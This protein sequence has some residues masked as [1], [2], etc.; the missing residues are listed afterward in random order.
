MLSTRESIK[1]LFENL[2]ERR[3]RRACPR[4]NSPLVTYIDLREGNG[5]IAL[6]ISESGLAITAAGMLFAD[7][8]RAIRFQLPKVPG[9]IETSGRV[10]WVGDS[11]KAAGISFENIT[12]VDRERIRHWISSQVS[13]DDEIA[14]GIS[15]LA[16]NNKRSL[17]DPEPG[18]HQDQRTPRKLKALSEADEARF[19]A[20]FPSEST[21]H[22]QTAVV[23]DW[24]ETEVER[25]V[26][27]RVSQGPGEFLEDISTPHSVREELRAE[28]TVESSIENT[29]ALPQSVGG[30]AELVS[31]DA[32]V[33]SDAAS[34]AVEPVDTIVF[35]RRR[36]IIDRPENACEVN[37]QAI[38]EEAVAQFETPDF[39]L[40]QNLRLSDGDRSTELSLSEHEESQFIQEGPKESISAEG[41]NPGEWALPTF[42]YPQE[43]DWRQ[44]FDWSREPAAT[45]PASQ[46]AAKRVPER[47]SLPLILG[48]GILFAATCFIAGLLLGNGS[49]RRLLRFNGNGE[50][51][52]ST[53]AIS[54]RNDSGNSNEMA[55][56][57]GKLESSNSPS[58]VSTNTSPSD[59]PGN[60]HGPTS[61]QPPKG[62]Q[63][64]RSETPKTGNDLKAPANDSI[65]EAEDEGAPSNASTASDS[66]K[67]SS[68]ISKDP[69][70]G[71]SPFKL[72]VPETRTQPRSPASGSQQADYESTVD[73]PY[74]EV[75]S[76]ILVT[77]PDEKS[78][79]FRL[80]F[81]EVAVSA[82]GA[83][84]ISAQRF[85]LVPTLP[86]P[87][88]G[89]RPARLQAGVLIYHVDP[90]PPAGSD[91]TGG[92]VKV[93]AMIGKGGDVVEVR[94]V[95][96]P[97]SLIPRVVRAVREWRYTVTLLD[98][99]PLGAE[100][101]VVVEFR[102]RR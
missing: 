102:P 99:Q 40:D 9:W 77:P 42:T 13:A 66:R 59:S 23:R 3:D 17:E 46:Q 58:N 8:F 82:S 101:D 65:Q 21:L 95:S 32:D 85:V 18:S 74:S 20:M 96:G 62:P 88:S 67:G 94:A 4:S 33:A 27:E 69:T 98:G 26:E 39:S 56:G 76:P 75:R 48:L 45:Q 25:E 92:T 70:P 63:S 7:Y 37:D 73:K 68:D 97:T 55:E 29:E 19:A 38:S 50:R 5:G 57:G 47:S 16:K 64:Y 41:K 53:P 14:H 1:D 36:W 87:A 78:G 43:R 72:A 86:G 34:P 35:P 22:L 84:A 52:S 79:P 10:V 54:S 30:N 93:R 83:L 49:F 28:P 80:A 100:E 90:V 6:N 91:N 31:T 81:P 12:E 24:T 71:P 11:K 44:Q 2:S 15:Y 61:V 51:A 60:F 89:H